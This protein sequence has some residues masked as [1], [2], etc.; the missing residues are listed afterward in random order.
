VEEMPN[1]G[2]ADITT[3]E[4]LGIQNVYLKDTS[5]ETPHSPE[6]FREQWQPNLDLEITNDI[7]NLEENI[8]EVVLHITATV[9]AKDKTAF[10]VEV[11]QAGIFTLKGFTP[12]NLAYMLNSYCPTLLFPFARETISS[13]VSRG[14]F[15]PLW[16]APINF[17][18]LYA[19]QMEK[20]K[21]AQ[22][23]TN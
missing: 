23:P 19:E 17:D 7:K 9:K 18:A 1:L 13:L 4:D 22:N 10:L 3:K 5:F 2:D 6:I 15:Q 11:Q 8:Y 20:Q 16:L 12:D 14:G 21:E